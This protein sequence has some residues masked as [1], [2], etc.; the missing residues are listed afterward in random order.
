M[1]AKEYIINKQIQW[2]MNNGISLISSKKNRGRAAYT[3]ELDNN[4]F[5]PLD[6]EILNSFII[7]DGNEV[8]GDNGNPSK[9][10]A[11]HSSSALGVNIFQYWQKV[12][13]VPEI[14][15]ACG[16][17]R[18]GSLVSEKILFE[19]KCPI[20]LGFQFPP[21]IDVVISNSNNSQ[22]KYFAVECKFSEAYGSRNQKGLK[23]DYLEL[24][25]I[26]K[27]IPKLLKYSKS[28][29][30]D[31]KFNKYLEPAQLIKHILGLK[32]K[33]HGKNKFRLM[34]LWYDV[35]G[36]EGAKHREEIEKF[37]NVT[38]SDNIKF[39]AMSY[40]ELIVKLAKE[41]RKD[42]D[43]YINYITERYL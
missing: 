37:K 18:K 24:R 25:E 36:E 6:P 9:M 1:K 39:H 2:A 10:Q 42:H 38:D 5:H 33:A 16:F 11:V 34:Y 14:A 8:K 29:S 41:Y 26:W 28:I 21:N 15:A 30:P 12:N 4:L 13:K 3:K 32:Q 43:K 17:C 31:D 7:G 22:Y 35:L 19:Y 27:D 40:Q 23:S 20:D